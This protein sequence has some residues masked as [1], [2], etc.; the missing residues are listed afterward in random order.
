M[1]MSRGG[2]PKQYLKLTGENT[3]IEHT[4][5]RLLFASLGG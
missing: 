5:L 1:A 2:Y 4:A 3:L